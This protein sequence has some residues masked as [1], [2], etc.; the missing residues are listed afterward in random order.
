MREVLDEAFELLWPDIVIAHAKDLD[1][2]GE[3]GHKPAGKG[4]LDYDHYLGLL[5]QTVVRDVG[6]GTS[7]QI[8]FALRLNF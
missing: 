3:A 2:D 4:L 6:L 7:R 1:Q 8:Q 5:R